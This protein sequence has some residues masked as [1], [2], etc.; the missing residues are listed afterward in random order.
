M[1]EKMVECEE[2]NLKELKEFIN[3]NV[4]PQILTYIPYGIGMIRETPN[5]KYKMANGFIGRAS[6]K[7]GNIEE[8]KWLKNVN[9]Y[10]LFYEVVM[11]DVKKRIKLTKEERAY[12]R[13]LKRKYELVNSPLYD[14]LKYDLSISLLFLIE[15][16][17][18]LIKNMNWIY[19]VIMNVC[20]IHIKNIGSIA[21]L[22]III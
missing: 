3:E 14:Y 15:L 4:V 2:K 19:I 22:P 17:H 20:Y 13:E 12:F 8:P 18:I 11:K 5:M 21:M 7:R 16:F 10:C 9:L 1:N 6:I